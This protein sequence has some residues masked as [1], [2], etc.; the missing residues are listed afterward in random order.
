MSSGPNLNAG[1]TARD[2]AMIVGTM[3]G[4]VIAVLLFSLTALGLMGLCVYAGTVLLGTAASLLVVYQCLRVLTRNL[5]AAIWHGMWLLTS[6]LLSSW[7]ILKY[8][9]AIAILI[10][11]MLGFVL[12]GVIGDRISRLCAQRSISGEVESPQDAR[13]RTHRIMR[14]TP[15]DYPGGVAGERIVPLVTVGFLV[16][17]MMMFWG[18]YLDL[19][20]LADDLKDSWAVLS[21]FALGYSAVRLVS[22]ILKEK[23]YDVRLFFQFLPPALLARLVGDVELPKAD[24]AGLGG[25]FRRFAN[26]IR[27]MFRDLYSMSV[28]H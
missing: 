19:F 16:T 11:M 8:Q 1:Q 23:L 9:D 10:G 28:Q 14:L 2:L 6:L 17:L 4:G 22:V 5:R 12:V 3:V 15:A 18:S 20:G 24:T 26:D 21:G 13:G 7:F 27:M 25:T